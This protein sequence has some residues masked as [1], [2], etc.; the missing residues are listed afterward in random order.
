MGM[1]G[2]GSGDQ[3]KRLDQMREWLPRSPNTS[4]YSHSNFIS[5][6]CRGI[7]PSQNGGSNPRFQ[8]RAE[9]LPNAIKE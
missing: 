2:G 7:D 4:R 5:L 6:G 9:A 1:L 8:E 3:E